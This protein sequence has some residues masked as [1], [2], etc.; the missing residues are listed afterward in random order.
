MYI[1]VGLTNISE[2]KSSVRIKLQVYNYINYTV[3]K[4][5]LHLIGYI[6]VH[7]ELASHLTCFL[8][9]TVLSESAFWSAC[10]FIIE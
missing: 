9:L 5:L 8:L 7:V 4:V 10:N 6:H 2:R 3:N 1:D